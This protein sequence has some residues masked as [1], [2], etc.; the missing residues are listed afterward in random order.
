[1]IC[2]SIGTLAY[3]IV[4]ATSAAIPQPIGWLGIIA[5]ILVGFSTGIKLVK[6][7]VRDFTTIGGLTAILFEVIIGGWLLFLPL[8]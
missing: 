2:W 5:S 4:I 7:D 8:I 3:S 1:M 6:L